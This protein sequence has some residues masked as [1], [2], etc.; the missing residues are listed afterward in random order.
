MCK[1]A[2]HPPLL[3]ILE[4]FITQNRIGIPFKNILSKTEGAAII[5]DDVQRGLGTFPQ[6]ANLRR[7]TQREIQENE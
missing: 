6:Q 3:A 5:A 4:T 2:Q 1:S 7:M